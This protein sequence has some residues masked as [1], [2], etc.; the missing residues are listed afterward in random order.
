M[1]WALWREADLRVEGGDDRL[2]WEA[3][4]IWGHGDVLSM[5]P[6]RAMSG[7]ATLQQR[8]WGSPWSG[9]TPEAMLMPKIQVHSS[10][11]PIHDLLGRVNGP[12]LW[13]QS[14]RVSVTQG[15]NRISQRS[16]VRSQYWHC[17]RQP[18][19]WNWS[20]CSEHLQV[21]LFRQRPYCVIHTPRH[22]VRA[23]FFF[24]FYFCFLFSFEGG[25]CKGGEQR[26]R[27]WGSRYEI[28]KD[29]KVFKKCLTLSKDMFHWACWVCPAN[30]GLVSCVICH[31]WDLQLS[32]P[33]SS[34]HMW[35]SHMRWSGSAGLH[36]QASPAQCVTSRM[37]PRGSFCI[38][39]ETEMFWRVGFRDLQDLFKREYKINH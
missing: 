11:F 21:K 15:N 30:L 12:V 33:A 8:P 39:I 17:S 37:S 29:S 31:P 1:A 23:F 34:A 36:N 4:A 10:I 20:Q 19:A 27:D 6:S 22:A 25:S 2:T 9:L 5:L 14:C 13:I 26:W 32:L 16:L 35:E 7:S 28:H 18:E 38:W 3:C 24:F